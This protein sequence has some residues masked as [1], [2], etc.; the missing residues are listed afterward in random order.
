MLSIVTQYSEK[1]NPVQLYTD[2]QLNNMTPIVSVGYNSV[3]S[4]Q[5]SN[6]NYLIV[7][8][9]FYMAENFLFK[10]ILIEVVCLI[11]LHTN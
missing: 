8:V 1:C 11:D 7:T 3:S 5:S 9:T 6:F 2:I 10:R 4:L